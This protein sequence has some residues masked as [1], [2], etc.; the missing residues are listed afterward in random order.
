MPESI[1][2]PGC[3]KSYRLK[4]ELQGRKVK[5]VQCGQQFA[6][7]P[8][9]VVAEP[10][11]EIIEAEPVQPPV[12]PLNGLLDEELTGGPAVASPAASVADSPFTAGGPLQSTKKQRKRSRQQISI[13]LDGGLKGFLAKRKALVAYVL[14]VLLFS[15]LYGGVGFP[16]VTV[17]YV[18]LVGLAIAPFGLLPYP[19]PGQSKSGAIVAVVCAVGIFANL[20]MRVYSGD[21]KAPPG[22]PTAVMYGFYIGVAVG[23]TVMVGLLAIWCFV[24]RRF[25]FFRVAACS[26]LLF[27]GGVAPVI[28]LPPLM[29]SRTASTAPQE[30]PPSFK[31]FAPFQDRPRMPSTGAA[32]ARSTKRVPDQQYDS[33][34][35]QNIAD[36]NRLAVY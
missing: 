14:V 35:R 13:S 3:A 6:I 25:G 12:D 1:Q 4:P 34:A 9:K 10:V 31:G 17:V 21:L 24:F 27:F 5:C 2:C 7:A 11:L 32:S 16:G 20:L 30:E 19:A 29:H 8:A 28:L 18:A 23:L 22:S 26:Y 33:Q 36:F 15:F